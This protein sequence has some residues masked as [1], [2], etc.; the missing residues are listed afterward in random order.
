MTSICRLDAIE[1][2]SVA[3]EVKIAPVEGEGLLLHNEGAAGGY[4]SHIKLLF[5]WWVGKYIF[6]H[7]ALAM[8]A[9]PQ[10]FSPMV[11]RILAAP[12]MT[13]GVVWVR[14]LVV[15]AEVC[16]F[17][18]EHIAIVLCAPVSPLEHFLMPHCAV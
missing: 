2:P 1:H 12:I 11:Y 6:W 16:A 9:M 7:Y 5:G 18:C 3:D 13:T 14:V 8:R 4:T 15:V 17:G 10:T